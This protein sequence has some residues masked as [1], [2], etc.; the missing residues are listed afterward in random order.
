MNTDGNQKVSSGFSNKEVI[1]DDGKE[2]WFEGMRRRHI[3]LGSLIH[4][5]SKYVISMTCQ[6]QGVGDTME[7]IDITSTPGRESH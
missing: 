4:S 2:F 3:G 7:K 5:F 1:G 6:V